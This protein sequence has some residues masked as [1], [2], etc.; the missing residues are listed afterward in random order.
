M[1]DSDNK[2]LDNVKMGFGSGADA[3]DFAGADAWILFDGT[4]LII[5]GASGGGEIIYGDAADTVANKITL[6][7]GGTDKPGQ[8]RLFS[9]NADFFIWFDQ[10][11]VLRTHTA[12]PSDE[13]ADGAQ[14][15]THPEVGG[16]TTLGKAANALASVLALYDGGTDKPGHLQMFS[17]NAD[18]FM[19]FDNNGVLRTHTA[20]PADE[21]ADGSL[22]LVHPEVGGVTVLGKA[23]NTVASEIELFDGGS[24]KPALVV[25]YDHA[26][27]P[28]YLWVDN[29]G[30]L[31]IGTAKPTDE[32]ADGAIVGTQS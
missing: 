9:Q 14:V 26:G 24:E 19:W 23:A 28:Y 30:D 31:R 5:V 2:L 29:T 25:L 22:V 18:F 1:S 11:G 10:N 21:D 13:D 16:T 12:A 7:D 3:D 17:Q 27:V 15:L 20:A 32:D 8:L 4:N 6:Y